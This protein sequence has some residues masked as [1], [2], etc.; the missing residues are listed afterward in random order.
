[1]LGRNEPCHCG[2]GKKYKKCCMDKDAKAARGA[3]GYHPNPNAPK[4]QPGMLGAIALG[5]SSGR[6]C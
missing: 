1:M 5:L 6:V 2:S 4:L 3:K